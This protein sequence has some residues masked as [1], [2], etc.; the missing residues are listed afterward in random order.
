[1]C[2]LSFLSREMRTREMYVMSNKVLCNVAV[3]EPTTIDGIQVIH[4]SSICA[5]CCHLVKFVLTHMYL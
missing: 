4:E 3:T 2:E 5:S 1:M